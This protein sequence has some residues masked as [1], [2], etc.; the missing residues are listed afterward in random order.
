MAGLLV[1][2]GIASGTKP[3]WFTNPG[4]VHAAHTYS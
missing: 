1:V 3:E 2:V 4:R